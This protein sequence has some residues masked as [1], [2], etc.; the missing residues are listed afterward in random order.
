MR[1][2]E[3]IAA[4]VLVATAVLPALAEAQE[5]PSPLEFCRDLSYT[6]EQA[7]AYRQGGVSLHAVHRHMEPRRALE[8][9]II[10]KAYETPAFEYS[11]HQQQ[12]IIVYSDSVLS[13]C[14]DALDN[15]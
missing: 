8:A 2:L 15:E 14:L 11:G 3:I 13:T 7:M 5:G 4:A 6:A 12:A 1:K 10:A 9:D